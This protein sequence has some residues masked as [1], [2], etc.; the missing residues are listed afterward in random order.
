MQQRFELPKVP[1]FGVAFWLTELTITGLGSSVTATLMTII[2]QPATLL[3]ACVAMGTLLTSQCQ[4]E[5]YQ[6]G[7]YWATVTSLVVMETAFIDLMVAGLGIS[8]EGL[9][10][11][12]GGS[13]SVIIWRWRALKESLTV[14][15]IVT[16]QAEKDYWLITIV[17][18]LFGSATNSWVTTVFQLARVTQLISLSGLLLVSVFGYQMSHQRLVKLI[19]FIGATSLLQPVGMTA[20]TYLA[21]GQPALGYQLVDLLWLGALSV[22]IIYG[23]KKRDVKA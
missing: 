20:A 5:D 3:I 19:A 8:D 17:S 14:T 22:L 4:N 2:S 23:F 13:G 21:L 9:L 10:M 1:N 15:R 7:F 11:I 18:F 6:P 16:A 12:A